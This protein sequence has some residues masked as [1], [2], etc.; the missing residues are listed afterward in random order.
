MPKVPPAAPPS[1]P[2]NAQRALRAQEIAMKFVAFG[3][4]AQL[5]GSTATVEHW[6]LR[7]ASDGDG[8]CQRW[9]G[10]VRWWLSGGSR[11]VDVTGCSHSWMVSW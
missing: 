1:Q 8:G 11:L 5:R 3:F 2:R 9:M 7:R 6:L 10:M 4:Q